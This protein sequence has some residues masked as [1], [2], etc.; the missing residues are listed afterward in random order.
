M[1]P[2][3][4]ILT[5]IGV[6]HL[7]SLCFIPESPR[8]LMKQGRDDEATRVLEYLHRT[9]HDP[10][11]AFTHGEAKQIKA[12][13]EAEENTPSGSLHILRTSS[14]RKCTLWGILL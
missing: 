9:K 14:H 12:Q 10:M 2:C 13:V 5:A 7:V 8:W 11:A 4:I 1:A 6:L 3:F